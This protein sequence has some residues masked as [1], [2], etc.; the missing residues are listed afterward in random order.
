MKN[1]HKVL[2]ILFGLFS[3]VVLL[4]WTLRLGGFQS[5]D[6]SVD[7]DQDAYRILALGEGPTESVWPGGKVKSWPT[8]LETI[9][10][11]KSTTTRY[12]VYNEGIGEQVLLIPRIPTTYSS[13]M[14]K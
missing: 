13:V 6:D 4:E 14:E 10:N 11:N 2:L 9:L 7:Y 8:H 5:E 3:L 1:V 12:R